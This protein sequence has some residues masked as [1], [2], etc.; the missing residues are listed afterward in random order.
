M[1]SGNVG[2]SEFGDLRFRRGRDGTQEA[3]LMETLHLIIGKMEQMHKDGLP[4]QADNLPESSA[5]C[6]LALRR[7][8]HEPLDP[9]QAPKQLRLVLF[10]DGKMEF[11]AHGLRIPITKRLVER[12]FSKETH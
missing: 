8:T 4:R 12:A 2:I 1:R 11:Q 9:A 6:F 7:L 10:P 5:L 3:D